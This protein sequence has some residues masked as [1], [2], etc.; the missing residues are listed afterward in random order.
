VALSLTNTFYGDRVFSFVGTWKTVAGPFYRAYFL[1]IF[2]LLVTMTL[3]LARVYWGLTWS[4]DSPLPLVTAISAILFLAMLLAFPYFRG[5]EMSRCY[6]AVRLGEACAKVRIG[7]RRLALQYF[8]FL[9]L[10]GL[11][12]T[13]LYFAASAYFVGGGA[14]MSGRVWVFSL[15]PLAGLTA[16]GFWMELIVDFGF[17]SRIASGASFTGLAT[18]IEVRQREDDAD[19]RGEGLADALNIGAF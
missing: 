18:L 2:P 4:P 19:A 17:W 8:M 14:S 5:R 7:A 15:L 11:S 16:L 6:S 12:I 1:G 13:V 3:G 10:T 9:L